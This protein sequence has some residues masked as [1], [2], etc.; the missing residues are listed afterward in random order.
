MTSVTETRGLRGAPS[1]M[2]SIK[3]KQKKLGSD[4]FKINKFKMLKKSKTG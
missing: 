2:E 4:E 1:A 3:N